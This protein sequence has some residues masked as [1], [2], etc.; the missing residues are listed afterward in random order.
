MGVFARLSFLPVV[1]LFVLQTGCSDFA[2][3]TGTQTSIGSSRN[4][5]TVPSSTTI[6]P[7][8][9]Q[10]V[11]VAPNATAY[12]P[13][14]TD[15]YDLFWKGPQWND[16]LGKT[17]VYQFGW[18]GMVKYTPAE[19]IGAVAM[20]NRR[21]LKVAYETGGMWDCGDKSASMA[22]KIKRAAAIGTQEIMS[23]IQPIYDAGGYM[24]YVSLDQSGIGAITNNTPCNMD[25]TSAISALAIMM[26]NVH[27]QHPEIQFGILPNFPNYAY[28]GTSCYFVDCPV[29]GGQDYAQVL[30]QIV[31]TIEDSG[32]S[33]T[34]MNVDNPQNYLTGHYGGINVVTQRLLP[35]KAQAESYGLRF[36]LIMN[37]EVLPSVADKDAAFYNLTTAGVQNMA[38]AGLLSES[39]FIT[40]SWYTYPAAI[41]PET[42]S[43]TFTNTALIATN[44]FLTLKP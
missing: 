29:F 44:L 36:G 8:S 31:S 26:K 24:T 22:L 13:A 28:N 33:F 9:V 6:E 7:L 19:M 4:A 16:L 37:S 5:V 11:W 20:F 34:Y 3:L 27:A 25:V 40:E 42:T 32:E 18:E 30:Y 1:G 21:N 39:N 14:A 41:L 43:N 2:S 12:D 10:E 38:A 15:S 17:N 23:N 35:L